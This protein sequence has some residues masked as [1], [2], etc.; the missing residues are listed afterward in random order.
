MLVSLDHVLV[1]ATAHRAVF[2]SRPRRY[3]FGCRNYGDIPGLVNAADGDPWDVFAPGYEWRALA[4]GRP[5]RIRSV[6]GVYLLANGNHKI[7]I[8]VH[9]P[10]YDEDRARREI[11][12]FCRAYT[13]GTGVPGV[14]MRA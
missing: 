5:Y 9:A 10:G 6:M 14:W 11:E 12:R 4:V 7:A 1:H 3:M 13:R 2:E 8:R